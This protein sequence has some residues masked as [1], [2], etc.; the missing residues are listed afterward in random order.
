MDEEKIVREFND[1][2][3]HLELEYYKEKKRELAKEIKEA[4]KAGDEKKLSEILQEFDRV[5]KLTHNS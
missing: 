3:K 1:L 5:S 2:L 4:E